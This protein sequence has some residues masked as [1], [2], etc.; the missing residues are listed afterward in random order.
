MFR[1]LRGKLGDVVFRRGRNGKTTVTKIPNMTEVTW[2]EAQ[3]AHR[4]K[5]KKAVAYA[6]SAMAAPE[7]W[8]VY[9]ELA[10]RK[11]KRAWEVAMEDY[12]QGNDLLS[13]K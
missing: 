8:A 11:R 4:Q 10:A 6:K 12:F 3:K 7:V 1:E 9:Q 13:K 2:S 5:F